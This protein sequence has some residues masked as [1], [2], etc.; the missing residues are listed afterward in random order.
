MGI[1]AMFTPPTG[2]P[3]RLGQWRRDALEQSVR[4]A[5]SGCSRE[6]S[7]WMRN[8]IAILRLKPGK[9]HEK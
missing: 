1:L 4:R 9:L 2:W 8:L 5:W 7:E 6:L 3:G